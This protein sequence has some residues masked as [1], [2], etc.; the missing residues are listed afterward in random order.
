[1]YGFVTGC[2]LA[3]AAVLFFC[4]A[5]EYLPCSAPALSRLFAVRSPCTSLDCSQRESQEG[6]MTCAYIIESL[7]KDVL[8]NYELVNPLVLRAAICMAR[9]VDAVRRH[10]SVVSQRRAHARTMSP[11]CAVNVTPFLT[12]SCA[13][14]AFPLG[15]FVWA[16]S[17]SRARTMV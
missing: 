10:Q 6:A 9:A 5:L 16:A 7:L 12:V 3:H 11:I 17:T 13:T 1:M 15:A 4:M 8:W 14:A 2:A